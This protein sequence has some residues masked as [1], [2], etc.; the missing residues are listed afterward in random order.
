MENNVE[1][2]HSMRRRRQLSM[3]AGT[4]VI[5]IIRGTGLLMRAIEPTG[6]R[7]VEIVCQVR[8]TS[9]SI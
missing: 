8:E 7:K 6:G 9:Q 1:R 4:F 3:K 2:A 5:L